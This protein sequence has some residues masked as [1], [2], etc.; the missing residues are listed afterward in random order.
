[1]KLYIKNLLQKL[2][3]INYRHY[4]CAGITLCFALLNIFVFKYSFP[5]I[6]ESIKDFGS[7]CKYYFMSIIRPGYDGYATVNELSS[8]PWDLAFNIP[9]TW[10]EFLTKNSA[11][12]TTFINLENFRAYNQ[13][14]TKVLYYVSQFLIIIIPIISVF[15]VIGAFKSDE[16]NNNYNQDTKALKRYKTFLKHVYEP[17]RDWLIGFKN[18]LTENKI[19]KTIW[20]WI[21]AINFNVVTIFIEFIAFYFYFVSS[22]K[23]VTV[24][25]QVYKLVFDL[26]VAINFVPLIIWLT[27]GFILFDKLC[28][29]I[30][31]K[32]LQHLEA[33]NCGWTNERAICLLIV[34][35][36]GK[37]KTTALSDVSLSQDVMFRDKAFEKILECDL[38]FPYFPW[39]E[40]ENDLKKAIEKHKIYTLASC[41]EF[42]DKRYKRF[43][44]KPNDK[45]LYGY[46]YNRYGYT[47]DNK[48]YVTD[49]WE[50][51]KDY[52]QLYFIYIVESSFIVSNYSI[53]T[54]NVKQDV[55]NFP[56]WDTDFFKR[57]SRLIDAYS[58][59]SH[60]LDFD[61]FRLGHKFVENNKYA[62]YLEFGVFNMTE[63]GKE[64]GNALDLQELKK[65]T[66]ETNQKND[67]FN[68]RLKLIRHHATVDGYPFVRI[69]TDEQRMASWGADA[70][71]LCDVVNI[72]E[73][74]EFQLTLPCFHLRD[75]VISWL[76]DKFQKAY[77]THRFYR[78]DNTLKI[79]IYKQVVSKLYSYRLGIY[80]TF[81]Y[82]KLKISVSKG[83]Q[84]GAV[85]DTKYYL[86][87]KKI[88]A[89]RFSTDCYSDIFTSKTLRSAVGL[90]DVP[91][92]K[93]VKAT[94]EELMQQNSYFFNDLL[95]IK[96]NTADGSVRE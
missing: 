34:G 96:N 95:K 1:M 77:Y 56:L 80:N 18:F 64:R 30:G 83:T 40:L 69:L 22:F 78:G 16:Q 7:S 74:C 66:D 68:A 19:Y 88:Y 76:L 15:L 73:K 41:R 93:G 46:D 75:L 91:E 45:N 25:L 57:D 79:Y 55:G 27:V 59:H 28:K 23:F 50:V 38:K 35:E 3:S 52:A 21:W 85:K 44:K 53:R 90:A 17:T 81:G 36:M 47:Y 60:I 87:H 11:Y 86:C 8:Q 24:Y 67:M 62:D 37:G 72:D 84:D 10:E 94:L 33:K 43:I 63:I 70:R 31:Y 20:L 13:S 5:R 89:K 49:I 42:I 12:W 71:E 29:N 4:I 54:D 32:R 26:S 92:Y 6:W 58:R 2:K 82:N 39:I 48:L 61:A 51:I 14:F 65:K 9:S